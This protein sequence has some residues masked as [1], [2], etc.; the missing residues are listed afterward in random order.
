MA[1]TSEFYMIEDHYK[2][3]ILPAVVHLK[4]ADGSSMPPL[5]KATFHL[6]IAY[7][8][9]SCTFIISDKL[10]ETDILFCMDIQKRYSLLYCWDSGKQTSQMKE[11]SFFTYTRNCEQQHK[12]TVVESTLRIPPRH[13][14]IILIKIKGHNLKDPVAYFISNQHIN[15]GLDPNIHVVDGLYN[16]KDRS[17]LHIVVTNYTDKHVTFNKEQWIGH[18]H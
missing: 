2:T 3:K 18:I 11:G 16:I 7:F 9:F 8:N 1:H 12:T 5:G 6:H 10:P 15:N 13:N 4:T 14:G 17:A